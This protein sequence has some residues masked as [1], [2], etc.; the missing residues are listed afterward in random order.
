MIIVKISH[1]YPFSLA[2]CYVAIT[3]I[4]FHMQ[5]FIIKISHIHF[6]C[7]LMK[8]KR[9]ISLVDDDKSTPRKKAT[10]E[11]S[12]MLGNSGLSHCL[13]VKNFKRMIRKALN[14]CT[15]L[16]ELVYIA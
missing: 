16:S 10:V 12:R 11:Q 14:R 7:I 4:N 6:R 9:V 15:N 3:N 1:F 2:I 8:S 5:L 13:F